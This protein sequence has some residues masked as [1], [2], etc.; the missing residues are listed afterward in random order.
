MIK[1]K[2]LLILRN[3]S[4]KEFRDFEKFLHSDLY[5]GS[6]ALLPLFQILKSHFPRLDSPALEKK[7]VFRKLFPR[8]EFDENKMRHLLSVL[9]KAL[10]EFIVMRELAA[11]PMRKKLL[12]L[13]YYRRAGLEK[14]YVQIFDDALK[15]QQK[16]TIKDALWFFNQYLLEEKAYIYSQYQKSRSL[17]NN[18]QT[19]SDNLDLFYITNKLKHSGE[20]LTREMLLKVTYH[21]PLLDEVIAYV[22]QSSFTRYPAVH[23]YYLIILMHQEPEKNVHYHKLIEL[24][25]EHKGHFTR[26]ELVDMYVFAQNYCTNRINSGHSEYLR[27]IFSL[28]RKMIE[29]DAIYENGYV[30]P[31]VFKNIVTVG[32]RLEEYDWVEKFIENQKE[33]LDPKHKEHALNYNLAWLHYARKDF[34]KALRHLAHADMMDIF[35]QLGARCLQLKIYYET[36]EDSAFYA[37]TDSF[38]VYLRRNEQ[39]ADFQKNAHLLFV[40]TIKRLMRIRL[41]KDRQ[42]AAVLREELLEA[43]NV[44]DLNW[45]LKKLDEI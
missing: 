44:L 41:E 12:L 37:L 23:I 13:D 11:D 25:D 29:L 7:K 40:R 39:I 9:G 16:A 4:I 17:D 38:Y 15:S 3:F 24:L 45:F 32:I 43:K 26:E 27:E 36:L 30:R 42:A 10:E 18:L 22:D 31:N 19:L 21:K 5:Q 20:M 34:K 2:P 14:Y 8:E 33:K 35:Y 28:Y 1:S 6:N